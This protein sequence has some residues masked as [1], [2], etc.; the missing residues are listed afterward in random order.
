MSE[1]SDQWPRVHTCMRNWCPAQ[2]EDCKKC[3]EV[4]NIIRKHQQALRDYPDFLPVV[5]LPGHDPAPGG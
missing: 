5:D 2:S 3:D 1:R 4:I